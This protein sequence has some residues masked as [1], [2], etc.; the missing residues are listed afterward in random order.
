MS[1]QPP[2]DVDRSLA[3]KSFKAERR[4]WF[5]ELVARQVEPH[6]TAEVLAELETVSLATR[7]ALGKAH[8]E[9]VKANE[10]KLFAKAAIDIS[11]TAL[12]CL[13]DGGMSRADIIR[14]LNLYR[15]RGWRKDRHSDACP[16]RISG[17]IN[18]QFWRAL[19][20]RPDGLLSRSLIYSILAD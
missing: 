12:R 6:L 18:E 5:H 13:R 3:G 20:G 8:S 2:V 9:Y 10:H 7:Y 14:E 1:G 16:P 4:A 19:K 11:D 17:T 15:D